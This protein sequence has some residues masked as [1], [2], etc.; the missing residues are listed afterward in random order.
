MTDEEQR[1]RDV[2]A[3]LSAVDERQLGFDRQLAAVWVE[4]RQV[5][6]E[7]VSEYKKLREEQ[8]GDSDRLLNAIYA[9]KIAWSQMSGG[10]RALAWMIGLMLA[11]PSAGYALWMAVKRLF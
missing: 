8:R 9:N 11:I 7:Q 5:R 6:Q 2:E 10:A 3:K 4:L 1:L